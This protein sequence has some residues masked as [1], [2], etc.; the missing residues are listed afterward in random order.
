MKIKVLLN[1]GLN[2]WKKKETMK[3]QSFIII[4][5]NKFENYLY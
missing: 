4:N 3:K 1:L 2:G 5:F